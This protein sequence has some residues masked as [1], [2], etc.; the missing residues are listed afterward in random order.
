MFVD[1]L[2]AHAEADAV[3]LEKTAGGGFYLGIVAD[4]EFC[5]G[6]SG[7]GEL[8]ASEITREPVTTTVSEF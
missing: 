1:V 2:A 7:V 5:H 6:W 4:E 8:A 3:V